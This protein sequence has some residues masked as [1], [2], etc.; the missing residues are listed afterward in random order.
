MDV[1]LP[2]VSKD[3]L[4]I[5]VD[6]AKGTLMIEAQRNTGE[7]HKDVQQQGKEKEGKEDYWW[8][9]ERTSGKLQRVLQLPETA[10]LHKAEV[11]DAARV[12]RWC[13]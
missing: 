7:T 11:R 2:G 1:D 12:G 10:D 13:D 8:R 6:D 3:Q 4:N 9:K 5:S